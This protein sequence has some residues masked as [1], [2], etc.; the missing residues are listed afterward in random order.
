MLLFCNPSLNL[1]LGTGVKFNFFFQVAK[2]CKWPI[3]STSRI[4][5]V[6][7]VFATQPHVLT[8]LKWE[9]YENNVAKQEIAFHEHFLHY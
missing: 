1:F 6:L 8:T 5:F 3:F 9:T 2:I 4:N 7:A